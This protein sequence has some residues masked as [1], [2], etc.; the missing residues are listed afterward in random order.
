[1]TSLTRILACLGKREGWGRRGE[2]RKEGE[3][4]SLEERAEVKVRDKSK[5]HCQ[6]RM[7]CSGQAHS[8]VWD[9]LYSS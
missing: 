3:E 9:L 1:M 7:S 2:E 8:T 4:R 6:E 5:R